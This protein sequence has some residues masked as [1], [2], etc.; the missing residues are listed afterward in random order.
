MMYRLALALVCGLALATP[1]LSGAARSRTLIPPSHCPCGHPAWSSLGSGSVSSKAPWTKNRVYYARTP[2]QAVGWLPYVTQR[3]RRSVEHLNFSESGVFAVF[4]KEPGTGPVTSLS[5]SSVDYVKH[6]LAAEIRANVCNDTIRLPGIAPACVASRDNPNPWGRYVVVAIRKRSLYEQIER[7]YAYQVPPPLDC[8]TEPPPSAC[9]VTTAPT[10]TLPLADGNPPPGPPA[11]IHVPARHQA[12]WK[13]VSEAITPVP[14]NRIFYA[15]VPSQT[16]AWKSRLS[17]YDR[18]SQVQQD[19]T[20]TGLLAIFLTSRALGF[21]IDG[22]YASEDGSLTVQIRAAPPPPP[23]PP[24][25]TSEVCAVPIIPGIAGGSVY[26]LIA[27]RKGSLPAPV[28]R[29]Y[30]AETS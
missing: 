7:V 29:L 5:L 4:F 22:V 1:P 28:K 3:D 15:R 18:T 11:T 23:P 27:V 30:I 24:P 12:D 6:G 20:H 9:V 25:C 26:L 13:L 16:N 14:A 21:T 8:S 2:G 10:P 19:F 17:L